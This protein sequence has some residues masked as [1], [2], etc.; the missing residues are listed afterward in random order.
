MS[1]QRSLL[2]A[3]CSSKSEKFNL[4]DIKMLVGKEDQPWFKW[5]DLRRYLAIAHIIKLTSK[6]EEEDMKSWVF[7][8]AEGG[9][10]TTYP[11]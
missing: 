3:S 11:P 9:I 4:H 5:A 1:A 8:Q 6:L 10:G 7:L 2:N